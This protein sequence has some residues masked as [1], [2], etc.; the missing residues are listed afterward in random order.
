ML[1]DGVVVGRDPFHRELFGA[2]LVFVD[3]AEA[4]RDWLG[5]GRR[6][7]NLPPDLVVDLEIFFDGVPRLLRNHQQAYSQFRHY[8]HRLGRDGCRVC[9][10]FE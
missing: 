10:A 2:V 7:V 3:D 8:R 6:A 1:H 5:C 4:A 9:T